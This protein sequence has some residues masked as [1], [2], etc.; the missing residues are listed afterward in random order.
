MKDMKALI[1][2]FFVNFSVVFSS[3]L[4][5]DNAIM[6]SD[7]GKS[8][9][10]KGT[11]SLSDKSGKKIP[12]EI[13]ALTQKNA[14]KIAKLRYRLNGKYNH[15]LLAADCY[16]SAD[17]TPSIRLLSKKRPSTVVIDASYI[18]SNKTLVIGTGMLPLNAKNDDIKQTI[19]GLQGTLSLVKK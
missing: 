19:G 7:F 13:L 6:C 17:Q 12:V 15:I 11:L 9:T 3:L 5:A 10:W 2:V 1:I 8:M 14:W 4:L 18:P 16:A